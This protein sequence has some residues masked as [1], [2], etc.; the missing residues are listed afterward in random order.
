[1][2]TVLL[3]EYKESEIDLSSKDANFIAHGELGR[4]IKIW[5]SAQSDK[6]I[7]NPQQHVGVVQLPSGKLLE[8]RPKVPVENIF[9][10]LAKSVGAPWTEHY[11]QLERFDDILELI[12]GLFADEAE[13][14]IAGGLHRTYQE[15]VDNLSTIRGR[16]DF[17][18]DLRINSFMRHRVFCRYDEL[19]LDIPENQVI[20]QTSRILNGWGFSNKELASRLSY[21]GQ[22]LSVLTPTAFTGSVVEE[23]VYNRMTEHYRTIHRLCQL[24]LDGA[25]LSEHSGAYDTPAFIVDMNKLFESFVTQSLKENLRD[26]KYLLEEQYRLYLD[27]NRQYLMKP[28][29]TLRD[30]NRISLVADCKYKKLTDGMSSNADMYQVLSYCIAT[31]SQHGILIYPLHEVGNLSNVPIV[32]SSTVIRQMTIDLGSSISELIIATEYLAKDISD[33]LI[34]EAPAA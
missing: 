16:I 8:S 17:N 29:I 22:K 3:H 31:G 9:Y 18:E 2:D 26:S 14:I 30:F 21:I 23:F 32:N 25:S 33:L 12:A 6:Y 11:A 7:L 10:M 13:Q 20:F 1:M 19:T 4:K 28:D 5:R 15:Q 24:L 34:E 27:T